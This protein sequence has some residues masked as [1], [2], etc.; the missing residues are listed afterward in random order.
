MVNI[1]YQKYFLKSFSPFYKLCQAFGIFYATT[2]DKPFAVLPKTKRPNKC[3]DVT[4]LTGS[5][6]VHEDGRAVGT[7]GCGGCCTGT[8]G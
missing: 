8:Q 4:I 3:D 5:C 6:W 7:A 1:Y 2:S